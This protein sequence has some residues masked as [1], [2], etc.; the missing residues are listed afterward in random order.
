M[1]TY[2]VHVPITAT[3]ENPLYMERYP[4]YLNSV[5]CHSYALCTNPKKEICI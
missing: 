5:D 3:D 2:A 1:R 4:V